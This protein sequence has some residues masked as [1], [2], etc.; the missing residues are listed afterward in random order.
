MFTEMSSVMTTPEPSS[1]MTKV[2]IPD[3]ETRYSLRVLSWLPKFPELIETWTLWLEESVLVT[4]TSLVIVMSD[5]TA[6]WYAR[7]CYLK[8]R[9]HKWGVNG[10]FSAPFV[11]IL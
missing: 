2:S 3:G 5:S 8:H 6:S 9:P 4:L 1:S 11:S 10:I 7:E